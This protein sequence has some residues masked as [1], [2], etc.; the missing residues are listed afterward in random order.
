MIGKVMAILYTPSLPSK[1]LEYTGICISFVSLAHSLSEKL[2]PTNLGR[3]LAA[4]LDF[5]ILFLSRMKSLSSGV[6]EFI[7]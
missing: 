7:C 5:T 6:L 2:T 1:P 4:I 3:S